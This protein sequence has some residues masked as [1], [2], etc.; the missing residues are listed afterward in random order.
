MNPL[1]ERHQLLTR[2]HFFGRSATGIGTV[3]ATNLVN[4][5][6][7]SAPQFSFTLSASPAN[8]TL[9][10]GAFGSTTI[11][12]LTILIVGIFLAW[13]YAKRLA[14]DP[15]LWGPTGAP[16]KGEAYFYADI[17]TGRV[18]PDQVP[19]EAKYEF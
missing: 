15:R 16:M 6:P 10:Q 13:W 18:G 1:Q 5:W 4:N 9:L 8:L 14:A 3:N 12:M 17:Q 7:S 2:R 19:A 11:T